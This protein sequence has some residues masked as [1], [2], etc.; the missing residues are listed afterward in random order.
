[1]V[2]YHIQ[3]I[4]PEPYPG[5][6]QSIHILFLKRSIP[7]WF[8]AYNFLYKHLTCPKCTTYPAYLH[9]LY[10]IIIILVTRKWKILK[11]VL[12]KHILCEKL[13]GCSYVDPKQSFILFLSLQ[14][15]QSYYIF[16]LLCTF[17]TCTTT[18]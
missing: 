15:L 7:L 4:L 16:F 3:N 12:S 14:V 10:L 17:I 5:P 8:A 2:H 1:M 6:A 11:F 18:Y 9:L 13:S